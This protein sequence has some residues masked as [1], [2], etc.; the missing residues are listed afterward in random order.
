[1]KR[2]QT[3]H[4]L[5][6]ALLL[7]ACPADESRSTAGETSPFSSAPATTSDTSPPD[8]STS[9][10]PTANSDSQTTD[11]SDSDT[12]SDIKLDVSSNFDLGGDDTGG[13]EIPPTC[14]NIE[15][16]PSTSVGC[17]FWGAQV[18]SSASALPYGISVGN[19]GEEVATIVIED[20]RGAGN[21]LR[22]VTTFTLDP[23]QSQLVSLN[24]TGG[25]LPGSHMVSPNGLSEV[26]AFRVTSDIPVTS[27]QIFPV[28]GGP[29]HV[30]EASLLLPTNALD[31]SYLGLGYPNTLGGNGF[32]T[33]VAT[34]DATTVTTSEGDVMLD[35]FD[36]WTYSVPEPTGFFVGSDQPVAVFGG[37]QCTL[38]PGQPWY[39]CDHLEE[40]L[41]PLA[42][43]G[44]EYVAP[45][46]PQ[47]VP[48]IN[49]APEDVY[50]RVVAAADDT[51]ITLDPPVFG[52]GTINLTSI[53]EFQEFATAESFTASGDQPFM[54]VQYMSGCYNVIDETAQP[55]TCNQGPTGDPYMIQV[56]PI[57]QWLRS[58]P[59]LTDTSYP[60][61][62]VMLMR[63]Q[64]TSI[65]LDCLGEVT[66][67]HF[68]A[69]AGTPYEVGYVDL[70]INGAG[71]EGAC[72]DGAQ[73]LTADGPVGVMVGG[74]DWATSYGYPGGMSLGSLWV[75]PQ[76]P[77][78]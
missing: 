25:L 45:R 1:M 26:A 54:L 69:I 43:W 8:T 44:Q 60:R 78:G 36:A 55:S 6:P 72:V 47:R 62:F 63:E 64:G 14:D 34:Q 16:F 61:D 52:G 42:T 58:L 40:Q 28:G 37:V 23:K 32:I 33:V 70:D 29:S 68:T 56:T 38:I 41:V 71:G 48:E 73:F 13:E 18:P 4:L 57:E 15:D 46:H 24:G 53:G 10:N 76:D 66:A 9:G 50:W 5:A 27:M 11:P 74:L 31:T 35:A 39:A 30:S 59:F 21:T 65:E 75:P 77:P 49:S 67:D 12:D 7:T 51:T 19:P 17:E 22:E 3:T 20:M 2:W